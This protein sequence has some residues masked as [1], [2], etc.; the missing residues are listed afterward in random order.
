MGSS[1]VFAN[2]VCVLDFDRDDDSMSLEVQKI[3]A[4]I[5]QVH[6]IMGAVPL[7]LVAC[8]TGDYEEVIVIAHAAEDPAQNDLVSLGYFKKTPALHSEP[9]TYEFREFLPEVFR[10]IHLELLKQKNNGQEINLRRVRWMSCLPQKVF[11]AYPEF[12]QT[13]QEFQI[14]LDLAPEQKLMSALLGESVTGFDKLW[15]SDSAQPD[16]ETTSQEWFFT[17]MDLKTYLVEQEG[18]SFALH[19][20]YRVRIR[21]LALGVGNR[22][23]AIFIK[24]K[25]ILGMRV[26]EIRNLL[27]PRLDLSMGLGE[28]I[29][30]DVLP[31]FGL[32]LPTD[33]NSEGISLSFLSDI[34]IEKIY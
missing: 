27:A 10:V 7:D 12:L 24:Y 5:P 9:A 22:W 11:A 33:F 3:F 16:P 19:G 28:D 20:R 23:T 29:E 18:A 2:P 26:G 6:L 1:W 34:K 13:L 31:R 14:P 17:Y 21:G 15:L 25:D 32:N 8:M 4:D 30:F